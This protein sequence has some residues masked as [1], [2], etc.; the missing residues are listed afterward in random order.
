MYTSSISFE[1]MLF[2]SNFL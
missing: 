1:K 2:P